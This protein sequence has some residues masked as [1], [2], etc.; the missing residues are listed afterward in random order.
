M[1]HILK[2]KNKTIR[3]EGGGEAKKE[4][5]IVS[6]EIPINC[7]GDRYCGVTG[8]FNADCCEEDVEQDESNIADPKST[9]RTSDCSGEVGPFQLSW[10]GK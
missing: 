9:N 6:F 8:I 5:H 2:I 4:V 1:I 3:P 7:S 10:D